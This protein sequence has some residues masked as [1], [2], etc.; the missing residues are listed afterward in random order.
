LSPFYLDLI[1][2]YLI[3][4]PFYNYFTSI[5]NYYLSGTNILKIKSWSKRKG[6][7]ADSG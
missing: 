5:A 6:F 7:G 2:F 4:F 1:S 3:L